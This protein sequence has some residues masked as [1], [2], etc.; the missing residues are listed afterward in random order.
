M[1]SGCSTDNVQP[2]VAAS[3]Q[4]LEKV[5]FILDYVPN[6]N[7]IG[8]YVAQSLGYYAE[9]GLDVEII[10]PSEGATA[11][12]IATGKG[13]FGVSYQEDVT[14]ARTADDPLPIK[15]IAAILQ[16]NTS[17]FASAKEKN[18][19]SPADF[20]NK[21]YAG[22]GS[23]AEEAIIKA[24]ME[25]AG[26]DPSKISFVQSTGSGSITALKD[27]VDLIWIYYGWTGVEFELSDFEFN[28]LPLTDLYPALDFYTPVII[29][30]ESYVTENPEITQKFLRATFRGYEYCIEHPQEA[31]ELFVAAVPDYTLEMI[32]KSVEYLNQYFIADAD[33]WG[34]MTADRWDAYTQFMIDS[35]LITK[36]MPAQE[37]FTNEFLPAKS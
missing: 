9:E 24:V 17:G 3:G 21:V 34:E 1:I 2:T 15:A 35:G 18:I 16:H 11:T 36:D 37:A 29:A 10:Q 7:H 4:Q 33:R 25:R 20:E 5:R 23:P 32:E 26:A 19:L 28:Y 12:L 27:A 6:T 13:E 30:A 8:A 22:W 14:Y 31:A